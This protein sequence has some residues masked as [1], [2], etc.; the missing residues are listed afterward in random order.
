[1]TKKPDTEGTLEIAVRNTERLLEVD[2]K[3][4]VEQANEIL[5][6]VPN[7]P[8]AQ[9]L[10]ISAQRKSGN[11]LLALDLI[12]RL[13]PEQSRWA[14]AHFEYALLLAVLGRG[15]DAIAALRTTVALKSQHPEAWRLLAD[16]LMAIGE[17]DGGDE[18]YARHIRSSVSDP[19]LQQAASA[20]IDNDI[21]KAERLLKAQLK[22]TPTDVPAIRMLAEVAVRCGNNDDAEKLLVRCLALAPSFTAARYNY[23]TLLHRLNKS[24][25]ALVEIERLLLESPSNPSYR[26]LTAVILSRVGDYGRSSLIYSQLLEEYPSNAKIWLSYGHVLK[27]EGRQEDCIAAYR[28]SIQHNPTFGEAY[29]SLANLKT[30]RFSMED[31]SAMKLQIRGS[32]ITQN[33]R[34]QFEFALGKAAEDAHDYALSFQHYNQGNSLYRESTRYDADG[35]SARTERLKRKFTAQFLKDR[36]GSGHDTAAPIFIVGMPRSGSTLLEQILASHS[37]VEGTTELPDIIS[38]ALEMS[39]E[40]GTKEISQYNDVLATK[41]LEELRELGAQ[42]IERTRVHRKTDSP[43]FIDKMPNN[44][45]H[46]GMIHLIL[47]NAKIID[48]RRHPLGC[49]FSNFKQYYAR[50]QNFSYSLSDIGRFYH[51]YVGLMTHF[52][53]VLPG[54]IHRVIYEDTVEDTEAQVR[55]LLAYC[56][57]DFE[58]ACLRFFEN[59]RGV[60]TA[61]SEQV[62]QPI[63]RQGMQQ[64]TNYE[65]WLKPLREALGPALDAYPDIP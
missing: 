28:Q 60:R 41:S 22:K 53:E 55:K 64:W 7:Y 24:S 21:P 51:D 27:T 6:A 46:I 65:P 16:H 61:S 31:M 45:L 49:C 44:F 20:M 33:D 52:D 8:P 43:F 54:R 37:L 35:N 63:Y 47:P 32:D 18:A 40:G 42:Y 58:P 17:S 3:L 59:Q 38:M 26:N 48:A 2:P 9:L 56:Q 50:G 36:I 34:V 11:Y 25:Q 15:N 62:R 12:E 29:W 19:Q 39:G 14:A 4:A 23:A 5:N 13:L 10:L 1:M 57:L 30:F